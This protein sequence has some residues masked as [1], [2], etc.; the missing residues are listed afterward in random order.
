V[1]LYGLTVTTIAEEIRSAF[2]VGPPPGQP[3][4]GHRC[5]ECDEVEDLMGGRTWV[6]VADDFPT[7]CHDAFPLLS[8]EAKT[9]YLPA[10]MCFDLTTSGWTA[11]ISLS[12]AFKHGEFAPEQFDNRQRS[13]IARWIE[14]YYRSEPSR[15]VPER[16]AAQW[17]VSPIGP[18]V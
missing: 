9:Y 7:Y 17:N 15:T 8:R 11:G 10:Y 2:P 12:S 13:A 16:V 4:T 1:T 14:H 3:I 6:D 18:A 5:D